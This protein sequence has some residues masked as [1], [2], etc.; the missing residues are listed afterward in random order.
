MRMFQKL[1]Y[2]KPYKLYNQ[3][4]FE[5]GKN[6]RVVGK[7]DKYVILD[8]KMRKLLYLIHIMSG[9]KYQLLQNITQGRIWESVQ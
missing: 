2:N 5:S 7:K 9:E 1:R 4:I 3:T 8:I 6:R